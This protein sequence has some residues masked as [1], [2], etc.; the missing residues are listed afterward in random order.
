MP[1]GRRF[2]SFSGLSAVTDECSHRRAQSRSGGAVWSRLFED[3]H[4]DWIAA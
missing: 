4:E 3:S 2:T 1:N